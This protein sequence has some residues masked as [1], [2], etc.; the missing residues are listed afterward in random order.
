MA[1]VGRGYNEAE[2]ITQGIL[3]VLDDKNLKQKLIQEGY[4][5]IKK[6]SWNKMAKETLQIYSNVTK[7]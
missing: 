7:T 5:Q 1:S 2:K 6:Y 3:Q 4:E